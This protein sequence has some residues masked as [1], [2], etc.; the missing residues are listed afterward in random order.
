MKV[1]GQTVVQTQ[2][3]TFLIQWTPQDKDAQGNYVVKQKILGVKMEINIGGN[4]IPYDS[5]SAAKQKNPMTDFF[6]QLTKE[7]LIFT[8]STDMKVIKV[9]G[10]EK[11]IKGLS[12]INP[13]MQNLLKKI[14]DEK[15]LKRMAEPTWYAFPPKGD[16]SKQTWSEK[17]DLDLGPIGKYDTNFDFTYKGADGTD[18]KIEFKTKLTYTAPTDKAGLPFVIHEAKLD[19]DSGTGTAV[20][21]RKDGRFKSTE[22]TMKLKGNL[23]IEVGSMKTTVEL[24]QEQTASS[25]TVAEYPSEWKGAK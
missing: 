14:L 19:S 25:T 21:S 16:L 24:T 23:T 6:D 20:F 13:Q 3:Q 17:S 8:I 4:K 12:D 10:H 9:E 7:E 2:D 15:A 22:L 11:F 1:M 5:T 18:E